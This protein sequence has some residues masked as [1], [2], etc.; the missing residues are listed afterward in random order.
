MKRSLAVAMAVAVVVLSSFALV[1]R[2]LAA[3]TSLTG[4]ITSAEAVTLSG[5]ERGIQSAHQVIG[6]VADG[7]APA[8]RPDLA[9][10]SIFVPLRSDLPVGFSVFARAHSAD[11]AGVLVPEVN[12]AIAA[13]APSM[14]WT[15]VET[16]S[17]VLAERSSDSRSMAFMVS[18]AGLVLSKDGR[19]DGRPDQAGDRN[20]RQRR[21]RRQDQGDTSISFELGYEADLIDPAANYVVRVAIV[22]GATTGG[23]PSR[24]RRSSAGAGGDAAGGQVEERRKR[25]R[26]PAP[27]SPASAVRQ[28]RAVRQRERERGADAE[29]E[30]RPPARQPAP[31]RPRRP[32]TPRARPDAGR[33]D[34]R[35][36]PR[37]P[38]PTPTTRARA[39]PDANAEPTAPR[40]RPRPPRRLPRRRPR[41]R[42]PRRP[43]HRARCRRRARRRRPVPRRAPHPRRLRA[44]RTAPSP[45]R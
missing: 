23:R 13:V 24:S 26:D 44:R 6:I 29:P 17:V 33:P 25:S 21:Q 7:S 1:G 36:R 37:P 34:A 3:V 35:R 28:R 42:R 40:R 39:D 27:P 10:G 45:A 12:R 9:S 32:P 19:G 38:T 16:A 30:C 20:A 2:T 43:R 4:S 41:P 11:E 15:K 14:P 22:D 5:L 31:P 18:A 8:P